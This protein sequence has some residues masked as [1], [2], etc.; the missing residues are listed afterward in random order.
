M[1]LETEVDKLSIPG[2]G[3]REVHADKFHHLLFGGDQLTAKCDRGS[4]HVRNN[5]LRGK[6]R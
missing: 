6:D 4:Q 3:E 1:P 2:V 5:F